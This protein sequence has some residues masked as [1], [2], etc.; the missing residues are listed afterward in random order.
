MRGG[1]AENGKAV[2]RRNCI[3]CHKVYNEGADYGPQM[4]SQKPVGTPAD[5][6]QDRRIDHRPERR[7]RSEVPLHGDRHRRRQDRDRP[8]GE[9]DEGPRG[10]LRRQGEAAIKTADIEER[11]SLKQSSMP[12]GTGRDHGSPVEFLDVVAF[13][14]TLK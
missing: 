3:A 9:R 14:G 12:E 2:F 8:A 11:T 5:A 7:R 13:L 4:D 10:P 1:N 6:V